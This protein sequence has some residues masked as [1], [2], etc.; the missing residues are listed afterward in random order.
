MGHSDVASFITL[1]ILL[2]GAWIILSRRR[3]ADDGP[4]YRSSPVL[5]AARASRTLREFPV[6]SSAK[7]A[8]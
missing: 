5:D 8:F 4:S 1:L 3:D 7:C 2:A 6:V